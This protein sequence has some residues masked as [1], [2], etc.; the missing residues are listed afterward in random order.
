M[1]P[2]RLAVC[3]TKSDSSTL[4]LRIARALRGGEEHVRVHD[5]R[6]D[7]RG[8]RDL[9]DARMIDADG[10]HQTAEERG[11]DVVDVLARRWRP[12]RPAIANFSSSSFGSGSGS[13]AL[14]ATTAATAEAAE[15]P[16]PEPSGMP[17]SI[18]T[19]N[20]KPGRSRLQQR[21]QRAP[22]GV[23]ASPR[24]ADLDRD[25]AHRADL[26]SGLAPGG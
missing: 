14:A 26:D 16:S 11:R 22:G 5:H 10:E 24:A 13:S 20:P 7:V 3:H 8:H 21:Q 23:V 19:A 6:A 12:P 9:L 2:A 25:A 17:F 15:P 1:K 18:S 4:R